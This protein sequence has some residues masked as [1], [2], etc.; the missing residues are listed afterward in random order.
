[1][2]DKISSLIYDAQTVNRHNPKS[3][4]DSGRGAIFSNEPSIESHIVHLGAPKWV[5]L[6]PFYG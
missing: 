3:Q 2:N 1:M 5:L 4:T 6:E